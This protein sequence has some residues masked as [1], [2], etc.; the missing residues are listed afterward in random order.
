VVKNR[1]HS[2]AETKKKGEILTSIRALK[3]GEC[4]GSRGKRKNQ[5][6]SQRK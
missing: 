2:G 5:R 6:C 1:D 4:G 3:R